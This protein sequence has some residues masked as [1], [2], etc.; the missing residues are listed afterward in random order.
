[1]LELYWNTNNHP[2]SRVHLKPNQKLLCLN[3]QSTHPTHCFRNIPLGVG[4]R[5][6]KL[7]TMTDDNMNAPLD[8]L[9]PTHYKALETAGLV[10]PS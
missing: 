5:L 7:T 10:K 4:Q 2:E 3:R 9:Y 6:A 1:M 8:F